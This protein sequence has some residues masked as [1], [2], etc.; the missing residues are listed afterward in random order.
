MSAESVAA[1]QKP[2]IFTDAECA[3]QFMLQYDIPS[4]SRDDVFEWISRFHFPG[5]RPWSSIAA[6][7][8]SEHIDGETFLMMSRRDWSTFSLLGQASISALV[9]CREKYISLIYA[10]SSAET[11]IVRKSDPSEPAAPSTPPQPGMEQS[12]LHDMDTDCCFI[13]FEPFN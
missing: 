10:V 5:D 7:L 13:L 9:A 2:L 11:S 4:W 3:A 8:W 12:E 1:V 6:Q